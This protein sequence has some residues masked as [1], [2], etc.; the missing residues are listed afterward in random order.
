MYPNFLPSLP[1]RGSRLTQT[2][3]WTVTLTQSAGSA[4]GCKSGEDGWFADWVRLHYF[5]VLHCT[6]LHCIVLYC[7]ELYCTLQHCTVLY[8]YSVLRKT[9]VEQSVAKLVGLFTI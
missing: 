3:E 7:S 1:I 6:V 9:P 2:P 4:R 5:I 8:Y